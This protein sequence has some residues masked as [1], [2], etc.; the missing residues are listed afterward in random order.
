VTCSGE[1]GR[2]ID[3][4]A[5][6]MRLNPYHPDWYLWHLGDAYFDLGDYEQTVLTLR[7]MRDQ[8]EAHRLLAASYA[9]L[10]QAAEARY[11]AEQLL[12]VHP[13]F[14]IAHWRRVSPD[15]SR[16]PVQRLIE[17]LLKAGLPDN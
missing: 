9:H 13:N 11:H 17:G 16:D 8:S 2:A 1:P 3:L 5:R 7:K 12:A 14:S 6:A 10:G 4:L 15:R